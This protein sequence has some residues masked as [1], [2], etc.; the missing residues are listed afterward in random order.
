M[1]IDELIIEWAYFAIILFVIIVLLFV[2]YITSPHEY[3]GYSLSLI[4]IIIVL[5]LMF[6]VTPMVQFYLLLCFLVLLFNIIF[7]T[8][9]PKFFTNDLE[10]IL[11]DKPPQVWDNFAEPPE[12]KIAEEGNR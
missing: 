2:G 7:N 9:I 10:K 3:K 5:T 4:G 12:L 11:I 6:F 8:I 1:T